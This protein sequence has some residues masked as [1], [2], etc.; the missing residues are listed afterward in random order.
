MTATIDNTSTPTQKG[1]PNRAQNRRAN[2]SSHGAGNNSRNPRRISNITK[3][4]GHKIKHS[5]TSAPLSQSITLSAL[6]GRACSAQID[7]HT[8]P[9]ENAATPSSSA[10]VA[11]LMDTLPRLSSA[12]IN[13]TSLCNIA[14][15]SRCNMLLRGGRTKDLSAGWSTRCGLAQSAERCREIVFLVDTPVEIE[16]GFSPSESTTS[17]KLSRYTFD[18]SGRGGFI[19]S[20]NH[21]SD[22]QSGFWMRLAAA[23]VG[24]QSGA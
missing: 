7:G 3:I 20:S 18:M 21:N 2:Q 23:P 9:S 16:K 11:K 14:V 6:G 10:K 5:A 22:K 8:M 1:A 13:V 24:L 12:P 15:T 4:N 19:A 17:P